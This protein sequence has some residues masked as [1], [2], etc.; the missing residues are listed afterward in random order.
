MRQSFSIKSFFVVFILGFT[1]GC[2]G[3][4]PLSDSEVGTENKKAFEASSNDVDKNEP[5][6]IFIDFVREID[7]LGW[8]A[9][10]VRVNKVGLYALDAVH[11]TLIQKLPFYK[12]QYDQTTVH[13]VL[14]YTFSKSHKKAD[15]ALS[16]VRQIWGYF[17]RD[18]AGVSWIADGMIE[19][20]SFSN[21][22]EAQE[23]YAELK[24]HGNNI[25][26][27]T[28]PFFYQIDESVFI[29]HTRAMAFSYYQKPLYE[30]FVLKVKD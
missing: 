25:Y 22:K 8:G 10:T 28:M 29:F 4:E 20:W 30:S 26:F 16:K 18:K 1:A 27:N 9:D 6:Q 17:Y 2:V 19:E 15:Q 23:A 3:E 7:S 13:N 5:S 24:K 14:R 21:E 11:P 12:L